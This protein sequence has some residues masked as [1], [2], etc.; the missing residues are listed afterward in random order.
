M[1]DDQGYEVNGVRLRTFG[2][3]IVLDGING[4]KLGPLDAIA[5]GIALVGRGEEIMR[6]IARDVTGEVFD[7]G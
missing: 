2:D 5:L 1:A 6:E 4:A 3:V 7:G